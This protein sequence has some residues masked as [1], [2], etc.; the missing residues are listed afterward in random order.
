MEHDH[1][2]ITVGVDGS[3]DSRAALAYALRDAVRRG[4]TV[5]VVASFAPPDYWVPLYGPPAIPFDEIQEGVR[6]DAEGIVHEMIEQ[7]KDELTQP[8]PVIVR[9]VAGGAAQALLQAAENADL[10]VVGSRGHG[11]FT[12][13]LLGSVSLSCALHSACPVTV[14]HSTKQA[15][16]E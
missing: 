2:H 4:A 16:N 8:P 14:V 3:P 1:C 9:A 12:S 13:M 5:E 7:M 11:G 6:R 10:L 15:K